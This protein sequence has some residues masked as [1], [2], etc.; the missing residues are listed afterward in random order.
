[1]RN[2]MLMYKKHF[3]KKYFYYEYFTNLV[4]FNLRKIKHRNDPYN[5]LILSAINDARINR[6]KLHSIYRPGW[7]Y[8][9]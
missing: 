3:P 5:N 6:K 2:K 9:K 7:K 8:Q 1:M 4:K